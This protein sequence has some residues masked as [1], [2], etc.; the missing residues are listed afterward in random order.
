MYN[1]K[2]FSQILKKK[3]IDNICDATNTNRQPYCL[4]LYVHILWVKLEI[5]LD[6]LI[7][8]W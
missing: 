1:S 6:L 5:I 2:I 3:S 7:M 8:F 4:L